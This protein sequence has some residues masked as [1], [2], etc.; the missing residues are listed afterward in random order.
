MFLF[1]PIRTASNVCSSSTGDQGHVYSTLFRCFQY[2]RSHPG[3]YISRAEPSFVHSIWQD[4]RIQ[5]FRRKLCRST[6]CVNEMGS[7]SEKEKMR[8]D[9]RI[10]YELDNYSRRRTCNWGGWE[11][12][13]CTWPKGD[14]KKQ[15]PGELNILEKREISQR[16]HFLQMK[17]SSMLSCWSMQVIWRAHP[18]KITQWMG[19]SWCTWRWTTWKRCTRIRRRSLTSSRNKDSKLCSRKQISGCAR[20]TESFLMYVLVRVHYTFCRDYP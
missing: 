3:E 5:H 15:D 18:S 14:G 7:S 1:L 6:R 13:L 2:P 20:N 11:G 19:K 9:N 12:H 8:R 17:N 16:I 4:S 10:F